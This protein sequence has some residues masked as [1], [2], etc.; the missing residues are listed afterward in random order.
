MATYYETSPT[1]T[2]NTWTSDAS[3]TDNSFYVSPTQTWGNWITDSGSTVYRSASDYS[4]TIRTWVTWV[5]RA[6]CV[7]DER[8]FHVEESRNQRE[9]REAMARA[10]HAQYEKIRKSVEERE[11][12]L[13]AAENVAKALLAELI[14]QDH[15]KKYEQT[16]KLMLQGQTGVF[17]LDKAGGHR[18]IKEKDKKKTITNLCIHLKD[19]QIY[20]PTDNI[21]ALKT[22]LEADEKQ[23]LLTANHSNTRELKEALPECAMLH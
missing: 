21:I 1:T 9:A 16:G 17:I 20:P 4:Y 18:F 23:F 7:V 3:S 5:D 22:L 10:Q 14:G 2:W 15:V 8:K 13:A 12:K 19:G 11:K 6:I